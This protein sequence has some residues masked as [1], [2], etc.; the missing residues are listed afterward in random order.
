VAWES[1]ILVF[2][3]A[4]DGKLQSI[5]AELMGG[6]K[7]LQA[8]I[9]QPIS[10]ALIGAG[11][12][13][14]AQEA[15]ALGADKVYVADD[16]LFK[17]Y[18]HDLHVTAAVNIAKQV[19]PNIILAGQTANGRD[20]APALAFHLNT[21]IVV[22]CVDFNVDAASKRMRAT[23]PFSG[24]NFRQVVGV[25]TQPQVATARVKA[26][27]AATP[28]ASRKGEVVKV[29]HGV[30]ASKARMK[31]VEYKPVKTEGVRLEDAG[32]V[33][34]GGR[35]IGG[36]EGFKDLENLAGILR[37]AVGASRAAT[38]SGFTRAERMVGITGVIVSPNLYVAVGISGSSQHMAGCGGSKNIVVI[39]KDPDASIFKDARFG[40]VGDYKMVLP[41]FIDEVKKLVQ[42]G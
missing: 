9:N 40:V 5:T 19:N 14:A 31:Y 30:D 23:R 33:I 24:G 16:P 39:N 10:V 11:V 4:K 28:D 15:I 22:D 1:G 27:D 36:P 41:A 34:S 2:G 37:G 17:N 21:G 42:A 38:D 12:A 20:L 32:V 8:G 18:V 35:G 6:A 26:I 7:K 13:A 3:E 29:N 25:K